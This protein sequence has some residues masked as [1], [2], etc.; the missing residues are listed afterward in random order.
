MN[1]V[2]DTSREDEGLAV[3]PRESPVA[4]Y[5][6]TDE[7]GLLGILRDE[8][9]WATD[10]EYLNDSAEIV[11]AR[12]E[13]VEQ[14]QAA[15]DQLSPGTGLAT[16]S[17]VQMR[18]ATLRSAANEFDHKS[19]DFGVYVSC[20]SEDGDS[21]SQWRSYGGYAIGFSADGLD[22][23]RPSRRGTLA[24]TDGHDRHGVCIARVSYGVDDPARRA[25]AE[26]VEELSKPLAG[27]PGATGSVRLHNVVLPVLATI[28][29]PCF[30]DEREWRLICGAGTSDLQAELRVGSVGVIPYIELLFDRSA[31]REVVVG[32]GHEP[33]LRQSGVRRLLRRYGYSSV[34]VVGTSASLRS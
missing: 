29:H 8:C 32:P 17:M 23:A 9:I 22:A 10:T 13:V 30:A 19:E 25:I 4:L 6:Y 20:F 3:P 21:L 24:E 5:H 1:I 28:K 27:F 31:V 2:P 15:A 26:A 33:A 34:E 12:R 14:M 7:K 18:A 11:Y 16:G